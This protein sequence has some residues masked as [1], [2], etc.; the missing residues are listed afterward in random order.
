[1]S[2]NHINITLRLSVCQEILETIHAQKLTSTKYHLPRNERKK[3]IT[4]QCKAF[5]C[6]ISICCIFC[7]RPRSCQLATSATPWQVPC[8]YKWTLS[9]C[10]QKIS[11]YPCLH[12]LTLLLFI[13]KEKY[14]YIL[15]SKFIVIV[16]LQFQNEFHRKILIHALSMR[17]GRVCL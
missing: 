13:H 3:Q 1:M 6:R 8:W 2:L 9:L 15:R 11:I 12:V 4:K 17:P 10:V 7:V 14:I 16:I 5:F